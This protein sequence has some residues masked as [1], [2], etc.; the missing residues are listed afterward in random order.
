MVWEEK[1]IQYLHPE[2]VEFFKQQVIPAAF[3]GARLFGLQLESCAP[4]TDGTETAD[5]KR[6]S[7]P[8]R[9][10]KEGTWAPE[11]YRHMAIIQL[12]ASQLA[13]LRH[14]DKGTAHRE[15]ENR[16]L[17]TLWREIEKGKGGMH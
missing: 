12:V 9:P 5:G 11:R 14:P 13:H 1:F 8:I 16:I 3:E 7:I 15:L 6:I 4:S 2:D 17:F 10:K